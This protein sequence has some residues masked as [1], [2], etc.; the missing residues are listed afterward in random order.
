MF[1][2]TVRVPLKPGSGEAYT[3]AIDGEIMPILKKFPGFIGEVNMV[4]T[5][6]KEGIGIS[7][8][9]SREH[10]EAYERKSYAEVLNVLERFAATKSELH[11]FDVTH[12]NVGK[13]PARK[14]A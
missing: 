11:T 10:A 13:V 3:R 9:E 2:R 8:W 1:A 12:W 14:V 6:G 4:S 7:L 5:D